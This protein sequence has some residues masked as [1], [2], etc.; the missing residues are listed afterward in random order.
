MLHTVVFERTERSEEEVEIKIPALL[1]WEDA[2]GKTW[3]VLGGKPVCS[4]AV[5]CLMDDTYDGMVEYGDDP[6]PEDEER[7][8]PLQG[9]YAVEGVYSS[10]TYWMKRAFDNTEAQAEFLEDCQCI[11]EEYEPSTMTPDQRFWRDRRPDRKWQKL[12]GISDSELV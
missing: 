7:L 3:I 8:M 9:D 11:L 2:N 4:H 6:D 5:Y 1:A 10:W 12:S